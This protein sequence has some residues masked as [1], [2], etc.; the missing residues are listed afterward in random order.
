MASIIFI[1]PDFVFTDDLLNKFMDDDRTKKVNAAMNDRLSKLSTKEAEI[2]KREFEAALK[3][4]KK[5]HI[6]KMLELKK[7]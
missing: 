2:A 5:E 1:S 3:I 6:K 4:P 7:V